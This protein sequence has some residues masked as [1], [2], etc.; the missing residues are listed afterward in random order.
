MQRFPYQEESWILG[1]ISLQE[2]RQSDMMRHLVEEHSVIYEEV[3]REQKKNLD[4]QTQLPVPRKIQRAKESTKRQG[5]ANRKIQT[6]FPFYRTNDL[7]SS[8]HT[9]THTHTH[10]CKGGGTLD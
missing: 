8:K 4:L 2:E 5:N 9:H 3:L 10:N 1:K 7:V 6:Q